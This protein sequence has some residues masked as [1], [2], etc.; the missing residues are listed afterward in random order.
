MYA[1]F[2]PLKVL[3]FAFKSVKF[4]LKK[5]NFASERYEILSLKN[6]KFCPERRVIL[7][8]KVGL[9]AIESVKFRFDMFKNFQLDTPHEDAVFHP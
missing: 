2:C 6:A 8:K 3:N 7:P 4:C 5:Q 1:K 9:F